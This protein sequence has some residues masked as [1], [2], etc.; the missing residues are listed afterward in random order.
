MS[1]FTVLVIG[2][3]PDTI[4]EPYAE[5]LECEPRIDQT[6]KQIKATFNEQKKKYKEKPEG[7]RDK[8]EKLTVSLNKPNAEWLK[9]WS[10][11]E[12]DE[13]GNALTT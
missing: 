6:A 9:E 3:N 8:F 7:E 13:D 4:L 10:G 5:N 11:Q 1:H 2:K 12:L